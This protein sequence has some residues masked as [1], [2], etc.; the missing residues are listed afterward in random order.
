M[1]TTPEY[2]RHETRALLRA[3]LSAA[4]RYGHA[5]RH[6]PV[7]HRLQRLA[8]EPA[9]EP[10]GGPSAAPSSVPRPEPP[11]PLVRPGQGLE[12]PR[13][14]RPGPTGPDGA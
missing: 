12:P 9:G 5:T 4:T 10:P 2:P 6:C 3:H 8:M 7:C 13:R 1:P 14:T 11:A